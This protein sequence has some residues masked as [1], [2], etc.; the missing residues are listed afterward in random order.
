MVI[1]TNRWSPDTCSCELEYSWDT[2]QKEDVRVHNFERVIRACPA[3]DSVVSARS[4]SKAEL[5]KVYDTVLEENQRKN[6]ALGKALEVR[7][8][9]AD[10][11]D[12]A[13]GKRHDLVQV[14]QQLKMEPSKAAAAVGGGMALKEGVNYTWRWVED[15][16]VKG[17][18]PARTLEIDF[19][20]TTP[21]LEDI[22]A[23]KSKDP[24]ASSQQIQQ[25]TKARLVGQPEQLQKAFDELFTLEKKR[26]RVQVK[27]EEGV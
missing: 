10:L 13:T 26:G 9:L 18:S 5:Q 2:E 11:V 21:A 19:E 7:P 15:K 17:G 25:Q 6:Q 1:V 3:H 20:T 22:I 24:Q 27:K 4:T 8:E 14:A 23:A 12:S 16:A